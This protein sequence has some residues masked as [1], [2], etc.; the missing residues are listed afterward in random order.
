MKRLVL[1]LIH[2]ERGGEALECALVT[3]FIAVL[4]ISV[5]GAIGRKIQVLWTGIDAAL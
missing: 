4:S 1:N 2:D 3:G 5:V